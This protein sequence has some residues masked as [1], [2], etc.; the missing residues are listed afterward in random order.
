MAAQTPLA[1][2]PGNPRGSSQDC[3]RGPAPQPLTPGLTQDQFTCLHLSWNGHKMRS[4]SSFPLKKE[5]DKGGEDTEMEPK[6]P[7]QNEQNGG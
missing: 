2:S 4:P 5:K 1:E 7:N 3:E 6:E